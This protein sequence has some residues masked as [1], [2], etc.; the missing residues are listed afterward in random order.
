MQELTAGFLDRGHQVQGVCITIWV[1]SLPVLRRNEDRMAFHYITIWLD[2]L[3]EGFAV[4]AILN[5]VLVGSR[6]SPGG[7]KPPGVRDLLY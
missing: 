1:H 6:T 2:N 7:H 4:R 3:G 5:L